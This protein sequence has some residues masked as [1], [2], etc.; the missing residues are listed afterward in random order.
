[1]TQPTLT[2]D[3]LALL[4]TIAA[5]PLKGAGRIVALWDDLSVLLHAGLVKPDLRSDGLGVQYSI[6][7]RRGRDYLE[8]AKHETQS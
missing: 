3:Q 6:T 5:E 2:T 4:R 1:M 7:Q 8:A